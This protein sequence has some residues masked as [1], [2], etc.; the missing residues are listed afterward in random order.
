MS[1]KT[2]TQNEMQANVMTVISMLFDRSR[3]GTPQASDVAFFV[4][5]AS[6]TVHSSRTHAV[7]L[8]ANAVLTHWQEVSLKAQNGP[9]KALMRHV[10]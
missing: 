7:T 9:D 10:C 8:A 2:T 5:S 6:F 4:T 3:V 1:L